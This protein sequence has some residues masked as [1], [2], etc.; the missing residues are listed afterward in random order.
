[1]YVV[2]NAVTTVKLLLTILVLQVYKRF[3]II[4]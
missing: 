4:I 2:V 3:L 1:M